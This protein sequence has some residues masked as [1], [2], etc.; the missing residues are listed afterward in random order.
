MSNK[1][2][3]QNI[4]IEHS[5]TNDWIGEA[6]DTPVIFAGKLCGTIL[7]L[8]AENKAFKEGINHRVC[9]SEMLELEAENKVLKNKLR[10]YELEE[11]HDMRYHDG[12]A[13]GLTEARQRYGEIEAESKALKSA[14]ALAM[15]VVDFYSDNNNWYKQ[16]QTSYTIIHRNDREGNHF[17]VVGGKLAREIKKRV[18]EILKPRPEFLNDHELN[19]E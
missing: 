18:E 4:M 3:W 17:I 10:S 7:K 9:A 16:N 15:K 14:M 19:M 8:E 11:E 13:D 2:D 12:V 1:R 6:N 5:T